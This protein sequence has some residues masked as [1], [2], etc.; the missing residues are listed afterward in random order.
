MPNHGGVTREAP[1]LV[2]MQREQE[3]SMGTSLYLVSS[4]RNRRGRVNRLSM[5]RIR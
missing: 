4:G 2:K 1:G 5:F 3:E